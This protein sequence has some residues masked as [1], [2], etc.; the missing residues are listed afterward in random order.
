VDPYNPG[1]AKYCPLCVN[2]IEVKSQYTLGELLSEDVI[3]NEIGQYVEDWDELD[4]DG[5]LDIIKMTYSAFYTIDD[6]VVRRLC[7]EN[8]SLTSS[9][10]GSSGGGSPEKTAGGKS[11]KKYSRRSMT[12]KKMT[13]RKRPRR[14]TSRRK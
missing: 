7:S 8:N 6:E 5:L 3:K 13:K 14:K 9:G 1:I 11:K 12:R 4:C 10:R 2:P